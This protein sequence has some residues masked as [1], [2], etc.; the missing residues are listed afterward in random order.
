[1]GSSNLASQ[2]QILDPMT[3]LKGFILT[4]ISIFRKLSSIFFRIVKGMLN[5][6]RH[7]QFLHNILVCGTEHSVKFISGLG[8]VTFLPIDPV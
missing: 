7:T 8:N 6:H 4:G 5:S 2:R 1:M 3:I